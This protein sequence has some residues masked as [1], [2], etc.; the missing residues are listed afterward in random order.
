[1]QALLAPPPPPP[2]VYRQVRRSSAP[3]LAELQSLARAGI[4]PHNIINLLTA[5]QSMENVKPSF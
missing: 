4:K 1:M 2:P 3:Q 5:S